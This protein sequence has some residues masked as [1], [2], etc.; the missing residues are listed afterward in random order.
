MSTRFD[1]FFF[2]LGVAAACVVST[3]D[4]R[5]TG[6][7]LG[8]DATAPPR[9]RER[10]V[11]I[12]ID[13]SVTTVWDQ[14][15]ATG[16]PDDELAWILPVRGAVV[17]S[18]GSDAF[19][20]SLDARTAPVVHAPPSACAASSGSPEVQV[21]ARTVVGPYEAA[22]LHGE[23][24]SRIVAWLREEGDAV[25]NELEPVLE[26]YVDE[27]FGFVA[28]KL[29]PGAGAEATRP[30]RVSFRG[31]LGALPLRVA[32]AGAAD[33]VALRVFVIA[34]DR[35]KPASHP[36]FSIDPTTLT[37]D[38]ATGRS[39]YAALRDDAAAQ[40]A[41]RA[42]ALESSLDLLRTSVSDDVRGAELPTT[43][44]APALDPGG[45]PPAEIGPKPAV[46]P[47]ASD[48][49]L[50]FGTQSVRRV[51]RLSAV[52]PAGALDVDLQ[53]ERDPVQSVLPRELHAAKAVNDLCA[54]VVAPMPGGPSCAV[55]GHARASHAGHA[56]LLVAAC[57]LAAAR[58]SRRRSATD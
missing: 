17:V 29:R 24:A 25:A 28:A 58:R 13:E 53:L 57:T 21:T 22:Q 20:S 49:D 50:A 54:P 11:A 32:H 7:L 12:A 44:P 2:V 15:D 42:F 40:F 37:W 39:D 41:G 33:H 4:A 23:D 48:V 38:H 10:R 27:G 18:V 8:A 47:D 5:A 6:G 34:D 26:A 16:L 56:A 31:P 46:S 3:G 55:P 35:F 43:D 52:L 9:V 19:L 14:I 36:A 45:E 51:T 1:R 30:I